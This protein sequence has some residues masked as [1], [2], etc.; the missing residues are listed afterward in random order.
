MPV[1]YHFD[2][3]I[4]VIVMVGEYSMDDIRTTILK[5]LTDLNCPS[6][7]VIIVDFSES[8]SIHTRTSNNV[9]AMASSLSILAKRFN[10]H[11]ALVAPDN[12]SYGLMRMGSVASEEAGFKPEVFRNYADARKWILS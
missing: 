11:V 2:L 9:N 7:P 4:V 6:N 8:R 1:T 10:N 5:S 12:L 3:N